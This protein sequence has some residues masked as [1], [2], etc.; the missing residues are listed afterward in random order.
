MLT[1]VGL[2]SA[3]AVAVTG[4]QLAAKG[5]RENSGEQAHYRWLGMT[6][7]YLARKG[8]TRMIIAGRKTDVW[9]PAAGG[10]PAPL[11]LFS[12]G[13]S[14]CGTQSS[15]LMRA[16]ADAGY[17]VIA[18]NHQDA[19]C[20]DGRWKLFGKLPDPPFHAF[21]RWNESS[22]ADRR[23]D[24]QEV[25]EAVLADPD[26]HADRDRIG[27][28]GHSPRRLHR[29]RSCRRL[30]EL[31]HQRHQGGGRP[32]SLVRALRRQP[33]SRRHRNSHRISGAAP[34]IWPS[35][36]TVKRKG[37]CYE[38]TPSPT[39][40]IELSGAGHLA[41]TDLT[42]KYQQQVTRYTL[43]WLDHYV[44]DAPACAV[45]P[46]GEQVRIRRVKEP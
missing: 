35:P 42:R 43:A 27:L 17:L 15:F 36:P 39:A 28:V 30:A 13:F 22:Y 32:L 38:G 23:D 9:R 26:F 5:F 10:R 2:F 20:A 8:A 24:M 6:S 3:L 46:K 18:P 7:D 33:Y 1:R 12:H 14:G 44:R 37:G 29:S 45:P 41:W 31:A 4:Q 40:F 11:I 19:R 16:L 25:M 34:W 21:R